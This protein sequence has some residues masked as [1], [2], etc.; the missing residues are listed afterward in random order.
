MAA[1]NHG[2]A[3]VIEL[4]GLLEIFAWVEALAAY[5]ASGDLARLAAP[6][7]AAGLEISLEARLQRAAFCERNLDAAEAA[8]TLSEVKNR[9]ARLTSPGLDLFRAQL[10]QRLAWAQNPRLWQQEAA[11]ARCYLDRGDWLRAAALLTESAITRHLEEL[12]QDPTSV[13]SR[14]AVHI[15]DAN[16]EDLKSLRNAL[17]H[18]GEP[19]GTRRRNQ[20]LT[21]VRSPTDLPQHLRQLAAALGLLLEPAPTSLRKGAAEP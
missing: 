13:S 15:E 2:V 14:A 19:R 12:G 7:R 20:T 4:D 11:L 21:C 18:T 16:F 9:I 10:G 3:T 8:R 6:L 5:D 1:D 17:A